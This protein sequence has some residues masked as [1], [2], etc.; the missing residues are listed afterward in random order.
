MK[1]KVHWL[2]L[3]LVLCGTAAAAEPDCDSDDPGFDVVDVFDRA[4]T[5][6]SD[7]DRCSPVGRIS[8]A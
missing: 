2:F 5:L 3:L 4:P 6:P 7:S 1:L 8:E